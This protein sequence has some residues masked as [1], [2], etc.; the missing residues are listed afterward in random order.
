MVFVRSGVFEG[1]AMGAIAPSPREYFEQ[2]TIYLTNGNFI[3]KLYYE[4]ICINDNKQ[5]NIDIYFI[6]KKKNK[7]YVSIC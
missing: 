4:K 3:K 7:K 2:E 5:V 6:L 1:V